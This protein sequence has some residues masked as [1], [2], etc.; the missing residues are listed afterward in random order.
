MSVAQVE[1]FVDREYSRH[2]EAPIPWPIEML[3]AAPDCPD[4]PF[5]KLNEFRL[6]HGSA[7]AFPERMYLST[8]Y[9]NPRWKG[10]RRLK[11]VVMLLE[12]APDSTPGTLKVVSPEECARNADTLTAEQVRMGSSSLHARMNV[13]TA[14]P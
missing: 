8:N 1:K 13:T 9:F 5:Y 4:H 10:L 6:P 14:M 7:L 3:S 12:W 2:E 11:N